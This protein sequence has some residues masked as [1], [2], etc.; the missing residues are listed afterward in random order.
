MNETSSV[1]RPRQPD[2]ID[3]PLTSGFAGRRSSLLQA[4][5]TRAARNIRPLIP[6]RPSIRTELPAPL[7]PHA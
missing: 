5:R 7:A 2:E 4:G 1:V 3:N 6:I